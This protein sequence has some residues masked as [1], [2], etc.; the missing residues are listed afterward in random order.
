MRR[1]DR[2]MIREQVL[3]LLAGLLFFVAIF[4]V[5]DI[6]EKL[7]SFLDNKVPLPVVVHFYLVSIPSIMTIVLPMSILLSC[8]LALGQIGR[9]HEPT[10]IQA[11]GL[12]L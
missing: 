5:V 2:Y 1:L 9:H 4:I 7:D 3:S 8:L 12:G 6:F 11:A 10:A